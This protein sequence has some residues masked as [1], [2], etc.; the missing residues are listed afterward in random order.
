MNHFWDLQGV[1]HREASQSDSR[2]TF[3]LLTLSFNFRCLTGGERCFQRLAWTCNLEHWNVARHFRMV[4]DSYLMSK[5]L[6][7]QTQYGRGQG[8][9]LSACEGPAGGNS[10]SCDDNSETS[11]WGI[12]P[13]CILRPCGSWLY[14]WIWGW[15]LW[16]RL[17][18][19][20]CS[21]P[22]A[23]DSFRDGHKT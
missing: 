3:L 13:G 9:W 12:H 17:R 5:F 14:F 2:L 19:S 22:P 20:E 11:S 16:P 23:T 15:G 8:S 18:H 4:L 10:T 1:S 6:G 21:I 7:T